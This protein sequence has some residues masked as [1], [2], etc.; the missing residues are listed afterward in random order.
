MTT[1][2]LR[3]SAC[4]GIVS[5]APYPH[6]AVAKVSIIR[7]D[8]ALYGHGVVDDHREYVQGSLFFQTH[9][10]SRLKFQK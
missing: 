8:G 1:L 7:G 10:V 9:G 5:L 6:R 3:T 2:P 4:A